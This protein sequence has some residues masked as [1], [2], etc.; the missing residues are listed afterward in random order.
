MVK[1]DYDSSKEPEHVR[2]LFIGGLDY[3]TT[4]DSLKKHFEQWGEIVDVVVMKD[5]K[6]KRSRG[7]GFITYSEASCVDDAQNARPHT[8]DG[9]VVEPKRAVPRT[10]IGRPESGATVKKL[11]IGGLKDEH[12]EHEIKDYFTSF[13]NVVNC[14]VICDKE[15]G[16]KKGFG[17]VEFDDYDPVDKICLQGSH[18]VKGR[19]ID[20]KKALSKAEMAKLGGGGGDRGGPRGGGGGGFGGG[21]RGGGDWNNSGNAWESQAMGGGGGGWGGNSGGGGGGY[22]GGGWGGGNSGGGGGGYN[23]GGYQQ[24]YS[25]GPMRSSYSA[26]GAGGRPSPYGG[27]AGGGGGYGG[28]GGGGGYGGSGGGGYGGGGSGG[29]YGGG[30]RY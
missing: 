16:K 28:G 22:G 4:D 17:F 8:V 14:T 19:R 29:G 26:G 9:R 13:G 10:E 3:K 5:P 27:N 15:T 18:I 11:F 30:R 2:K 7:F 24:S 6:T 1:N 20:V 25:G 21:G 12:D 23:G